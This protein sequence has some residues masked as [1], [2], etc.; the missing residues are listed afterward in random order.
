MIGEGVC[1]PGD[2]WGGRGGVVCGERQ[3]VVII[4]GP[5][6]TSHTHIL[7]SA[8]LTVI[9]YL[10]LFYVLHIPLSPSVPYVLCT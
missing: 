3:A 5:R 10:A 7:R 8:I 1:M 9:Y 6:L 2:G 4:E